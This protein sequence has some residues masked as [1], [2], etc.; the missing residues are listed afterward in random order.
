MAL[1][2]TDT[3]TNRLV[4][5]TGHEQK[6]VQTTAFDLQLNSASSD[7]RFHKLDRTRSLEWQHSIH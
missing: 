6:A 5:L 7:V 3:L 1:R 2:L 4:K